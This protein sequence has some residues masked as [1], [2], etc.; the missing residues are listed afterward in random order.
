[1]LTVKELVSKQQGGTDYEAP[2]VDTLADVDGDAI[3]ESCKE[4]GLNWTK[5]EIVTAINQGLRLKGIAKVCNT[6]EARTAGTFKR[7]VARFVAKGMS[8]EDAVKTA[9]MLK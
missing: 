1:M 3:H 8:K 6:P 9:E 7:N 5:G 2:Q 4:A